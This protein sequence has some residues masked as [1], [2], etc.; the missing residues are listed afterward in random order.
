MVVATGCELIASRPYREHDTRLPTVTSLQSLLLEIVSCI[1]YLLSSQGA[2]TAY[3]AISGPAQAAETFGD[4]HSA[5]T[6]MATAL[7]PNHYNMTNVT[8]GSP[9]QI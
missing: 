3:F 6:P 5:H 1:C 7:A 4:F 9:F 8:H 2:L